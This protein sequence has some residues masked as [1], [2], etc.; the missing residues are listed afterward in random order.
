MSVTE[1]IKTDICVI[2]AG[3]GGLSVAAGAVQMGASVV[4]FE[5]GLMGGD[6]LNY[7]CVP[8]KSLLAAGKMAQLG[9]Y[10][11]PFGVTYQDP[12]I[13]FA[14]VHAHVRSVI[15]TIKPHDSVERFEGLGVRVI[16]AHGQLQKGRKVVGGGVEV[17]AKWIVIATGSSPSVP[18]IDGLADTPFMTNETI[19][20]LTEAPD[21]LVVIGGGPIGIEMASAHRALGSEVTV[22][23]ALDILANDDPEMVSILKT[24][25][26]DQGIN[27]IDQATVKSATKSDEGITLTIDQ[28]G[29][30]RVIEGS[31]LL[32]A[33]GRK[34]NIANLGLD[35]AGLAHDAKGIKV[36]AR[37]RTS[38][39]RIFAIGDVSGGP[40][41]THVAGYHAGIV[42][43][44]I[45][46]RLPA[47]VDYRALPW[48]T[49]TDPELAQVGLSEAEAQKQHS[50][51]KTLSWSLQENDRAMAERRTE[52]QVKIVTTDKGKILGATILASHAGELIQPWCLAIS[53]GL[54][55]GAMASMIAPYP[56][57]G[58]A[59]KRAAGS[60]YTDKLFGP[61]TKKI[62]RFLMRFA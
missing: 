46:F 3:S 39:K 48:V 10:A 19:F 27:L 21:H 4:L 57:L 14:K 34:P 17:S 2:G 5:S 47:K 60:F 50:S 31:H 45:L 42:I 22:I 9:R 59:G 18:P 56:T 58:E 6:C 36:D 7:G 28:S 25:L 54:K 13:D 41:F 37:L 51:V 62:V 43:R 16:Q 52:G 35:E 32:V 61:T 20:D 8:S 40:Q 44:N 26:Q 53:Q 24:R 49:Y 30:S 55:I 12:D 11:E 1:T 33:A 29:T 38:D 15:D 23:E